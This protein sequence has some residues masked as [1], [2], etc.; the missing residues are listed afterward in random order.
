M[1]SSKS[2]NSHNLSFCRTKEK[3]GKGGTKGLMNTLMQLRKVP[4]IFSFS[5]KQTVY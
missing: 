1:L 3:D 4:S 2:L 5:L